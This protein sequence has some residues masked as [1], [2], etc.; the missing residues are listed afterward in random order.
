MKHHL[1]HYLPLTIFTIPSFP[2]APRRDFFRFYTLRS[3]SISIISYL[4]RAPVNENYE[5]NI[6]HLHL[7][8]Y[9]RFYT[10]AFSGRRSYIFNNHIGVLIKILSEYLLKYA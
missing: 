4:L 7:R 9:I 8:L 2:F 1:H 5:M 6:Y 10:S 3:I